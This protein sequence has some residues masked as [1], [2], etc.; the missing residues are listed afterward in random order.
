MPPQANP[1]RRP[2]TRMKRKR[3]RL[4]GGDTNT[5]NRRIDAPPKLEVVNQQ[6]EGATHSIYV[7]V[8]VRDTRP[9]YSLYKMDYPYH[10]C[11]LAPK[12]RSLHPLATLEIE[13]GRTF[14]SMQTRRRKWIVAVGSRH[15]IV[16][17][18]ETEEVIHGP[19][20]INRKDSPMLI[21][22]ED[23]I[24]ALSSCPMVKGKLD[25]EPWFEVL[26]L[27]RATVV[28]GRL[29]DCAWEELPS[30]PCLPCQLDAQE[31]FR[32]PVVIVQSYVVAGSYILLSVRSDKH[33]TYAFDT[34]SAE[35]RKVHGSKSL[36]F[37]GCPT[38][39]QH[40][41][42]GLYLGESSQN[43][44]RC[45]ALVRL[46]NPVISA[47]SIK[48]TSCEKE[49]DIKLSITEFPIKSSRTCNAVTALHYSSLDTGILFVRLEI[50]QTHNTLLG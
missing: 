2:L 33:A 29:E 15:S 28:D 22:V 23:K 30:P 44:H 11:S 21:A 26:D 39:Q 49:D 36:P 17:D 4:K 47:Y 27:S 37:I 16:F 48:L 32:P 3:H 14:V 43:N 34:V 25:F 8:N 24:Y 18:A 5:C 9:V 10:L 50:S 6:T 35:W 31:F 13:G 7:V 42:A 20:P 12:R 41:V 40:G 19:K 45:S 38:P 1:N 46:G